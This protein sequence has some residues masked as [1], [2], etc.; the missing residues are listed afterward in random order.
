MKIEK[1]NNNIIA[2]N[3]VHIINIIKYII[4]INFYIKY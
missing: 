3:I 1:A 4:F 2:E